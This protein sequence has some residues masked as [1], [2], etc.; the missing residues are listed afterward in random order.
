[1]PLRCARRRM[2]AQAAALKKYFGAAETSKTRDK[3]DSTAAL[4]DSEKPRI[5]YPLKNAEV[6][7]A[8]RADTADTAE[9]L[10]LDCPAAKF[11][12]DFGEVFS[13]V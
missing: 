12:E 7:F 5:E 2:P 8:S 11:G 3:V 1:M 13:A 6:A 10:R 9:L 4:G